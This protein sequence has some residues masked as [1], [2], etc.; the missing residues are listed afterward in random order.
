[1]LIDRRYYTEKTQLLYPYKYVYEYNITYV[2]HAVPVWSACDIDWNRFVNEIIGILTLN[3]NAYNLT[4]FVRWVH[5]IETK[6]VRVMTCKR[7]WTK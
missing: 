1:M 4:S 7:Q 2:G 5:D 3:N 6:L